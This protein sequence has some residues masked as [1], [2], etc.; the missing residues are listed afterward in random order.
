[1]RIGDN[2]TAL[3]FREIV[4][5]IDANPHWPHQLKMQR[6]A[7][8]EMNENTRRKTSMDGFERESRRPASALFI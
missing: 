4:A 6:R 8:A 3:E 7:E 1:M 5:F 2:R